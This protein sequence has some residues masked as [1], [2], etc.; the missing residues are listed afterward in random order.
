MLSNDSVTNVLY[1]LATGFLDR[2]VN[3]VAMSEEITE[4]ERAV[5]WHSL[6]ADQDHAVQARL[7]GDALRSLGAERHLVNECYRV[8]FY[9]AMTGKRMSSNPLYA[10]FAATALETRSTNGSITSRSMSVI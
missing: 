6:T 2:A 4:E 1:A 5:L 9:V 7:F 3:V 8:A 10:F